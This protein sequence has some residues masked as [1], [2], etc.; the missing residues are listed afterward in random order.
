MEFGGNDE[1]NKNLK[2]VTDFVVE[3][4]KKVISLRKKKYLLQINSEYLKNIVHRYEII[5]G[6]LATFALMIFILSV[7]FNTKANLINFYPTNCLGSWEN[8]TYAQGTPDVKSD[9]KKTD[10]S[11]EN[12]AVLNNSSGEL[13][14]G[15]FTGD[16]PKDTLPKKFIVRF[17]IHAS[18]EGLIT[19]D[20]TQDIFPEVTPN[21][22]VITDTEVTSD[23]KKETKET[24]TEIKEEDKSEKEKEVV[25]EIIPEVTPEPDSDSTIQTDPEPVSEPEVT[26]PAPEVVESPVV[27]FLKG[28]MSNV[29]AEEIIPENITEEVQEVKIEVLPETKKE[30]KI[31]EIKKEEKTETPSPDVIID[32]IKEISHE[33]R[34]V[35]EEAIAEASTDYLEVFYTLDGTEWKSLGKIDS[36]NIGNPYFEIPLERVTWEDLSKIQISVKSLYSIDKIPLFYLDSMWIET[37]Y[38][39]AVVNPIV[40]KYDFEV[41]TPKGK[42]KDAIVS[43]VE[44]TPEQLEPMK[45][46]RVD[47]WLNFLNTKDELPT[48]EAPAITEEDLPIDDISPIDD[49]LPEE[50][51]IQ[52]INTNVE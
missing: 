37:E 25:P 49:T 34:K 36:R 31:D 20:P 40:F 6:Y 38:G 5:L 28:F 22:E 16:I 18:S 4:G 48:E 10:Y 47:N 42:Y 26:P 39:E 7:S 17:S 44:L 50:N 19:S 45:Q 32:E 24:S 12:S 3:G 30:E 29:F 21:V 2:R 52:S 51:N 15:N 11:P 27:S 14:C 46:Q 13:F 23:K 33:A 8:P 9:D 41:D 1:K 35:N 43:G